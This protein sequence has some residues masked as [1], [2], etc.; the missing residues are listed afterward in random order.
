MGGLG[1]EDLLRGFTARAFTL[2]QVIMIDLSHL[3]AALTLN[4][5]A[6]WL[7]AGVQT[8]EAF[9]SAPF[10]VAASL[11]LVAKG[12]ALLH[13]KWNEYVAMERE[14]EGII[15][16]DPVWRN[17]ILTV[18]V[19]NKLTVELNNAL[20]VVTLP[21]VT[22]YLSFSA[23]AKDFPADFWPVVILSL[24]ACYVGIAGWITASK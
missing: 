21:L 12:G 13:R 18:A 22:L 6:V 11:A 8:R 5:F 23:L 19:S 20:A 9:V 14:A 1:F 15:P 7:V 2:A 4:L 17:P 16:D 10:I 24:S 3:L